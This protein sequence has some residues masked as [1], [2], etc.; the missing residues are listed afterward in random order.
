MIRS[1]DYA[2]SF[3]GCEFADIGCAHAPHPWLLSV[4]NSLLSGGEERAISILR[5]AKMDNGIVCESIDEH[6]GECA[7]GE[8]FATAAGFVCTPSGAL[9]E[10]LIMRN[11]VKFNGWTLTA[12]GPACDQFLESVSSPAPGRMGVRGC[13][14][15]RPQ[16]R[17]AG[18]RTLR[19]RHI[20]PHQRRLAHHRFCSPA[21][22]RLVPDRAGRGDGAVLLAV[23]RT[24]DLRTGEL[25]LE[26]TVSAA[27][28]QRRGHRAAGFP[29]WTPPA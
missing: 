27:G 29:P 22:P 17:P 25:S 12:S 7:T 14:A 23:T 4:A 21:H 10:A 20:R 18:R 13:A 28:H 3:A 1:P 2:Y 19:G 11:D 8:H 24:L 9:W 6:T 26:Y 5:R 15:F 16:E